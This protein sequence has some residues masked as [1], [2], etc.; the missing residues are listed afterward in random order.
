MASRITTTLAALFA[1][2]ICSCDGPVEKAIDC[3]RIC[4]EA[5]ECVSGDF[6]KSECRQECKSD[7]SQDEADDCENCLKDA[8][9]CGEN[10]KCAVACGGVG[11]AVFFK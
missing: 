3:A 6:D 10:V 5:D 2:T 11:L 9:S 1:L 7:A 8:D 4:D